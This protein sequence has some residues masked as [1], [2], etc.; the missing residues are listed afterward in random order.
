MATD[1]NTVLVEADR[2]VAEAAHRPQRQYAEII[3]RLSGGQGRKDDAER[4]AELRQVL[5]IG[6]DDIAADIEAGRQCI[7][8]Q[9]EIDDLR[10]DLAGLPA[11]RDLLD[12]I[13]DVDRQIMAACESLHERKCRLLVALDSR[14]SVERQAADADQ[15][16][17]ATRST[18][19]RLGA[20][21]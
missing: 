21:R 18:S 16:L 4:L 8:L 13:A 11:R 5:H 15:R 9:A 19:P 6:A 7:L 2:H 20:P 3:H 1:T 12:E 10:Q 17:R 14:R